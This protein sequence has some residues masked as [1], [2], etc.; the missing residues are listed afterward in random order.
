MDVAQSSL[1]PTTN[2]VEEDRREIFLFIRSINFETSVFNVRTG[3]R[4]FGITARRQCCYGCIPTSSTKPY[5]LKNPTWDGK[6]LRLMRYDVDCHEHVDLVFVASLDQTP[7]IDAIY[8]YKDVSEAEV[9][10]YLDGDGDIV[11]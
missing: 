9:G 4:I 11:E 2:V 6:A 3:T 8:H 5:T 10:G 7:E 1:I